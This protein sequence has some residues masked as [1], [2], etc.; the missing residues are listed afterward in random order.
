MLIRLEISNYALIENVK[1]DFHAGF[2]SITGET[3]AGKSILLQALNLLL[4]ERADTSILKQSEKKCILEAE[5]LIENYQLKDFFKANDLDYE[6]N[7][8]LRRE[9]NISGKSRAFINDSPVHIAQLKSIGEKLITI[10]TQHQTLSILDN[11]FQMDLLDHFSGHA[12]KVSDYGK[13]YAAFK[14]E[15]NEL[16]SLKLKEAENRK[17]KDYLDFLLN[18]LESAGLEKLDFDTLKSNADKIENAEKIRTSIAYAQSIFE[19]DSIAPSIAL[20]SLVETFDGLKNYDPEFAAISA[21]LLSLKIE[22]DDIERDVS[23]IGEDDLFSDEEAQMIKEKIELINSLLFKHNLN[24]IDELIALKSEIDNNLEAISSVEDRIEELSKSLSTKEKELLSR[25][26]EI[27]S[28]RKAAIPNLQAAVE[29]KLGN[30]AMEDAEMKIDLIPL[31]KLNKTG[32]DQ[33]EFQVKTNRGGQFTPLK[34][35]ASGGELSR[36]MLAILSILSAKKKLPTLIFDEIDT[37]VSG[38]VAT[39]I[40]KEFQTMG[41]TMQIIAITHLPQV[42]ARGRFHLH[43]NKQANEHKTSTT[44]NLLNEKAR[45]AIVA[46]MMSGEEISEAAMK[47]ASN[48]LSND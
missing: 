32:L 18:E 41:E 12:D 17:E 6:P 19:N 45:V 15:S 4:G 9:I 3:G 14:S 40:A 10:H 29:S 30:L 2:T 37:G 22:L 23:N 5:F 47:N 35:A 36:I 31:E 28:N 21:R 25:A 13:L 39:K 33:I 16:I 11:Q 42:A 43:V 1:L 27:Q 8:I 46:G 26:T 34:K 38:E 48:L 7:C 20:K 24:E 44:V